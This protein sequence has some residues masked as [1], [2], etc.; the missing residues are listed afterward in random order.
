MA[1]TSDYAIKPLLSYDESV[2]H[3]SALAMMCHV[4]SLVCLVLQMAADVTSQNIGA[5]SCK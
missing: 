1:H 5:F 2:F 3:R 4:I